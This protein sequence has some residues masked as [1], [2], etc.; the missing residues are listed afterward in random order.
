MPDA[1]E[2]TPDSEK[3]H[4]A[5]KSMKQVSFRLKRLTALTNDSSQGPDF[6]T[7]RD[8]ASRCKGDFKWQKAMKRETDVIHYKG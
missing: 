7:A 4:R 3:E 2:L 8:L 6:D 5:T 1:F